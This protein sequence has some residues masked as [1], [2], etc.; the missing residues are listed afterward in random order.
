MCEVEGVESVKCKSQLWPDNDAMHY[1]TYDLEQ[2]HQGS[3]IDL[4]TCRKWGCNDERLRTP[5]LSE[6]RRSQDR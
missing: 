6:G 1:Y 3:H 5:G 2:N 4:D